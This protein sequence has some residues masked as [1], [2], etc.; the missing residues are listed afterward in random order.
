MN[1]NDEEED[2]SLHYIDNEMFVVVEWTPV[3]EWTLTQEEEDE[4][5]TPEGMDW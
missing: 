2:V 5:E 4:R 3:V 1:P